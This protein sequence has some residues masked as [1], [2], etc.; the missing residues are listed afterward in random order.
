MTV[1]TMSFVMGC[2]MQFGDQR[3]SPPKVTIPQ[4]ENKPRA[5]NAKPRTALFFEEPEVEVEDAADPLA[6]PLPGDVPLLVPCGVV[7]EGL[8][9]G[10]GDATMKECRIV[11]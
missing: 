3:N 9:V 2:Y 7:V 4:T 10:A 11:C 1:G 6:V 8:A 5:S